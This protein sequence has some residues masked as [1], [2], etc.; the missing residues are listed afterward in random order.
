MK[1]AASPSMFIIA[2][3]PTGVCIGVSPVTTT[4]GVRMR[5][6]PSSEV[7]A[8][9]RPGPLVTDAMPSVPLACA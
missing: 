7:A 1:V 4:I 2:C 8:W 5:L 6:A 3:R 9:V